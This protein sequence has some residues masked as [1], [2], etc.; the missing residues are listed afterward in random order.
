MLRQ[1]KK[2]LSEVWLIHHVPD[3]LLMRQNN[4]SRSGGRLSFVKF[5]IYLMEVTIYL[6]ANR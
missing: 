2:R 5:S 4:T 3:R 6:I 1:N